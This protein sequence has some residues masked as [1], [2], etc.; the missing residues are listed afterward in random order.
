VRDWVSHPHCKNFHLEV[1]AVHIF[2]FTLVQVQSLTDTRM[3]SFPS[4]YSHGQLNQCP[5]TE[6]TVKV[7]S[8]TG[9]LELF[10]TS[11][12][13]MWLSWL[14]I[15][16]LLEGSK[17]ACAQSWPFT[18]LITLRYMHFIDPSCSPSA[19]DMKH[20]IM[21]IYDCTAIVSYWTHTISHIT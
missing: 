7:Q 2:M 13:A 20:V 10:T 11:K 16:W 4:L 19:Q 17:V 5:S 1:V 12:P 14:F 8:P 6:W 9:T 21:I 15:Q 18:K 3:P